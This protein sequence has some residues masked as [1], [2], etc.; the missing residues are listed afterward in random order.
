MI[1]ANYN[2]IDLIE[3]CRGMSRADFNEQ[4]QETNVSHRLL[5]RIPI[6]DQYAAFISTLL[7][8]VS[9]LPQK[10][11]ILNKPNN[12]KTISLDDQSTVMDEF[13]Q[14][15]NKPN[16]RK[17]VTFDD[18]PKYISV[19]D[20]STV[21][22]EFKQCYEEAKYELKQKIT[23]LFPTL[24]NWEIVDFPNENKR[25][26]RMPHPIVLERDL[27]RIRE[28]RRMKALEDGVL[29]TEIGLEIRILNANVSWIGDYV[30]FLSKND[31]KTVDVN[32]VRL[33]VYDK[34][35]EDLSMSLYRLKTNVNWKNE[36]VTSRLPA[37][38]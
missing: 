33:R 16:N 3:L 30:D 38:Y 28:I 26:D 35:S 27:R 5:E 25:D 1:Y 22:D 18:L 14:I 2:D 4:F 10:T 17:T 34:L 11:T 24:D 12:G 7:Q 29:L 8:T 32:T 13:K 31:I 19:D 36:Y 9:D 23:R 15:M 6:F 20:L 37:G 21:M